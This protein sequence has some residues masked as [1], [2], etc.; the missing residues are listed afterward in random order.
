MEVEEG[1][2]RGAG[3]GRRGDGGRERSVRRRRAQT[4][5]VR[6]KDLSLGA[7]RQAGGLKG[8]RGVRGCGADADV[9]GDAC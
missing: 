5:I 6:P 2:R 3:N 8:S 4:Q 9:V 1:A 7:G